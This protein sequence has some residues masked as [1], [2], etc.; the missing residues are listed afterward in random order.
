MTSWGTRHTLKRRVTD[1]YIQSVLV[2]LLIGAVIC[3]VGASVWL[4]LQ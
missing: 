2:G 3:A 4:A 1:S